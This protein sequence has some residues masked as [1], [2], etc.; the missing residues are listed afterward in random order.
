MILYSS[1]RWYFTRHYGILPFQSED[2]CLNMLPCIVGVDM[3]SLLA[4]H[5]FLGK[6]YTLHHLV[7]CLA[8][9]QSTLSL[10]LTFTIFIA[11]S[12][13]NQSIALLFILKISNFERG[14]KATWVVV[15]LTHTTRVLQINLWMNEWTC[16]LLNTI[17][18]QVVINH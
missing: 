10:I 6:F 11:I 4:L 15:Y 8:S 17:A 9:F 1:C 3:A 12:K 13:V 2:T 14:N 5:K 16:V 7:R 18:K